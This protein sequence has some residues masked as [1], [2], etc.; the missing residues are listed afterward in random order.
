[1]LA[2]ILLGANQDYLVDLAPADQQLLA[3]MH[4]VGMRSGSIQVSSLDSYHKDC[5]QQSTLY[6]KDTRHSLQEH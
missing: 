1:V 2:S 3:M 4:S 5:S 6:W